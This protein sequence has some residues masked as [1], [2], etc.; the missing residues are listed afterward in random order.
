MIHSRSSNPALL[1][2]DV[3]IEGGLV[4]LAEFTA[5]PGRTIDGLVSAPVVLMRDGRAAAVLLSVEAYEEMRDLI[6]LQEAVSE[7]LSDFADAR[8]VENER[9]M[10]WLKSLDTTNPRTR[11]EPV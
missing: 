10:E 2:T 11:P 8:Y 6:R 4:D 1:P 7:G 3:I 5:N 9:V